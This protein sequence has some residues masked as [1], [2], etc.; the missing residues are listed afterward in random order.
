MAVRVTI[1]QNSPVAVPNYSSSHRLGYKDPVRDMLA[2]QGYCSDQHQLVD[3]LYQQ[4]CWF[5]I[6]EAHKSVSINHS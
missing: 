5:S 6:N 1:P 2:F 3:P 4:G